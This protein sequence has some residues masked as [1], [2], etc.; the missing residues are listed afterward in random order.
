MD[1]TNAHKRSDAPRRDCHGGLDTWARIEWY[2][3]V[4]VVDTV[5]PTHERAE[6]LVKNASKWGT[7]IPDTETP[8]VRVRSDDFRDR[9]RTTRG[10]ELQGVEARRVFEK[11]ESLCASDDRV[12]QVMKDIDGVNTIV[13]DLSQSHRS[14]DR[15]D[16]GRRRLQVENEHLRKRLAEVLERNVRLEVEIEVLRS[17]RDA[18]G[19]DR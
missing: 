7:A 15:K 14:T 9:M 8:T 3:V 11:L 13:V 19:G 6:V 10:E 18:Q 2:G 5:Y 16:P 17:E 4:D 1:E 12:V